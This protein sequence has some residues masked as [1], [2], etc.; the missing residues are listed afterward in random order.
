MLPKPRGFVYTVAFHPDGS[1]VTFGTS[2]GTLG[3]WDLRQDTYRV[4]RAGHGGVGALTIDPS[5]R[6]LAW[7]QADGAVYLMD[8][9]SGNTTGMLRGHTQAV[10]SL[11]F[12]ADGRL[13]AS[14]SRDRSVLVWDIPARTLMAT[15]VGHAGSVNAVAFSPDAQHVV[16]ASADE[17]LKFCSVD[18]RN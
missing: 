10:T 8:V 2:D 18:R 3:T 12:S 9:E 15:F 13:L 5:G 1:S 4:I 11:S 14:A 7:S 16:S 6:T 17:T